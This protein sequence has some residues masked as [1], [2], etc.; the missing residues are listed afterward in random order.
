MGRR[1]DSGHVHI[2][3]CETPLLASATITWLGGD[4][5]GTPENTLLDRVGFTRSGSIGRS[6]KG[7]RL[8]AR[9][10]SMPPSADTADKGSL[11]SVINGISTNAESIELTVLVGINSK[12]C[13]F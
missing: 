3:P 5:S 13:V 2:S 12:F 11:F 7:V 8:R 4:L 9:E 10:S 6:V 1:F